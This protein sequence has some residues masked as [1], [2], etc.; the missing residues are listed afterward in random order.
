MK[1]HTS[2]D[3]F[4]KQLDVVAPPYPENPGLFDDATDWE[5]PPMP[6]DD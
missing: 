1:I 3:A 6:K 4:K 2:F 5:T